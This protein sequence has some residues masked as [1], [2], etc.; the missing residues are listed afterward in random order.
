MLGKSYGWFAFSALTCV[1]L[2]VL[3]RTIVAAQNL[4][5]GNPSIAIT[6]ASYGAVWPYNQTYPPKTVNGDGWQSAW[7]DLDRILMM[8]NDGSAWNSTGTSQKIQ[9]NTLTNTVMD[10]ST[11]GSVVNN[12]NTPWNTGTVGS[13]AG[14]NKVNGILS[15]HGTLYM[16]VTWFSGGTGTSYNSTLI[17]STDHGAS[18]TPLPTPSGYAGPNSSAMFPLQDNFPYGFVQYGKDYSGSGPDGSGT[19]IYST[20][21][22]SPSMGV[23]STGL[24]RVPLATIANMS[25]ADWQYWTGGDGMN[26]ANWASSIA[27]AAS[28]SDAHG[29]SGAY[30]L[31]LNYLPR[32]QKYFTIASTPPVVTTNTTFFDRVC[33]HPWGPCTDLPISHN[34]NP[35]GY[36]QPGL[37]EKSMVNGGQ[38]FV[39]AFAGDFSQ[40]G[41]PTG[42]YTLNLMTVTLA[43]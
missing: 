9:L 10:A 43:P 25:A 30:T 8:S 31:N 13:P 38:Q 18:F 41:S 6:G 11:V 14:T 40:A 39:M 17:K 33:D 26:N 28:I 5:G 42:H 22:L 21:N 20:V 23:F 2:V 32:Y 1:L 15:V 35:Q 24:A 3:L 36:Y 16:L 19:Y 37:I 27:S 12:M 29:T 34:W 7:D 4:S